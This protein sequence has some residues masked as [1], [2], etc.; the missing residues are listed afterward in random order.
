M[1]TVTESLAELAATH[2]SLERAWALMADEWSPD[3]APPTVVSSAM[4]KALMPVVG[5]LAA[6]ELSVIT[7]CIEKILAAADESAKDVV[8]TGFLE[9][10]V[11][12]ADEGG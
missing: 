6:Q 4:A 10:V 3:D 5:G 1:Q 11:A 7:T 12:A 8:A 2:P 9:A